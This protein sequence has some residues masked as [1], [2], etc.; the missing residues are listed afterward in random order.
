MDKYPQETA[1][2]CAEKFPI[3]ETVDTL[4][5]SDDILLEAYQQ[6]Y[7][8]LA[9]IIDSLL[10]NGCDTMYIDRIKEKIRKIPCKPEV[11][12][13]VKTQENTAKLQVLKDSCENL[14]KTF[15]TIIE[16][17]ETSIDKLTKANGKLKNQNRW[18]WLLLVIAAIWTFRKS[19]LSLV[20][21]IV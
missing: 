14:T 18:L 21:R 10:K 17:N 5:V 8:R 7:D 11:K 1:K 4:L 9:T 2:E 6:E 3:K 12:Y 16:K 13:I 20:K 19:I 15:V